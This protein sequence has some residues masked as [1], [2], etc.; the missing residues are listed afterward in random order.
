MGI[1]NVGFTAGRFRSSNGGRLLLSSWL[2]VE[3][4]EV[5]LG[6]AVAE[7]FASAGVLLVTSGG[8]GGYFPIVRGWQVSIV[9]M[10]SRGSGDV[11][12]DFRGMA[13][14]AVLT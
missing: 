2:V 3:T 4:V 6:L 9:I 1:W 7:M 12:G 8:D 14:A 5:L 13:V 11:V 10:V